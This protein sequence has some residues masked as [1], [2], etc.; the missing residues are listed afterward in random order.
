MFRLLLVLIGL[1]AI[2]AW[3]T[4]LV[5]SIQHQEWLFMIVGALL[6]PVAVVH[7]WATWL[8]YSWF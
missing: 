2:P 1:S 8:G 5:V 4:H 6:G 3:I 7:G